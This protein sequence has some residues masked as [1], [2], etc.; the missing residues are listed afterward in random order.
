MLIIATSI[1]PYF[2]LKCITIKK[3]FNNEHIYLKVK[4]LLNKALLSIDKYTV[5]EDNNE[6]IDDEKKN[7][8][9][10]K[11]KNI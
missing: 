8:Q 9:F 5:N 6:D 1:H 2:K 10:E 3:E 11:N 4:G 7:F